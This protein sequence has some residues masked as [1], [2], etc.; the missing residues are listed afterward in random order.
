MWHA[1]E[2]MITYDI[3]IDRTSLGNDRKRGNTANSVEMEKNIDMFSMK[4][5]IE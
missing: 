1:N 4:S 5:T 3:K 2:P